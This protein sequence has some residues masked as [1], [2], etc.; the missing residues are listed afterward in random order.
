[1]PDPR[2]RAHES[3]T[4]SGPPY[5]SG[6]RAGS[7]TSGTVALAK[8]S[9][10]IGSDHASAAPAEPYGRSPGGRCPGRLQQTG[11]AGTAVTHATATVASDS[12]SDR[13]NGVSRGT[14]PTRPAPPRRADQRRTRRS[15]NTPASTVPAVPPRSAA[16]AVPAPK[17][18]P[19]PDPRP[20]ARRTD[21]PARA[22]NSSTVVPRAA[23]ESPGSTTSAR[24]SRSESAPPPNRPGTSPSA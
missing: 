18:S 16:H 12:T 19:A 14:A 22:E 3:P 11:S 1:M 6:S 15:R 9:N 21:R 2:H 8:T 24:P 10:P 13:A 23:S 7:V 17:V 20:G 4:S 5:P